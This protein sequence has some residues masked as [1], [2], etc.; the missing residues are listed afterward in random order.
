MIAACTSS[1]RQSDSAS[2]TTMRS[3]TSGSSVR[4]P[5]SRGTSQRAATD[6][7]AAMVRRAPAA[8]PRASVVASARGELHR[9]VAAQEERRAQALLQV[10]DLLADGGLAQRQ[11][12]RSGR[13]AEKPG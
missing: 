8:I 5:G 6:W 4:N 7:S 13:E 9:P 2:E 3:A 12:P 11:L 10:A 1:S